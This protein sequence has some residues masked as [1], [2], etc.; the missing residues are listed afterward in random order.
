MKEVDIQVGENIAKL[1]LMPIDGSLDGAP[2]APQPAVLV[3]PGGAYAFVSQREGAPVARRFNAL[4]FHCF[5][6]IYSVAPARFPTQ[7]WQAARAMAYIRE[8]AKE[9][10][11]DPDRVF[12][13][14]FSAG[15]HLAASL[16][17][18][19]NSDVIREG[20]LAPEQCRPNGQILCY[21]V[22][23]SDKACTHIG[24]YENLLGT[25]DQAAWDA[26]SPE[27]LVCADTP[28]TF[29]FHTADDETVPVANS[30]RMAEALAKQGVP[31]ET[32]IFKSAFHGLSLGNET[33]AIVPEQIRPACACW[34]EL[35]AAF[36]RGLK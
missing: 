14:G 28:P 21:P 9:F 17:A 36:V 30:I 31:F 6:L 10:N 7:L 24:S 20:G 13:C 12:T 5:V 32:H 15:G 4:G 22:I 27:K 33:T 11:V 18:F 25:S 3:I 34:P 26:V 2:L 19:W 1:V 35:A 16:G 8:N 29:L 23:T